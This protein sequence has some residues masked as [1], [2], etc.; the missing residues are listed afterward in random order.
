MGISDQETPLGEGSVK[1]V[2]YLKALDDIGYT[3]FLTI[4]RECG[5]DPAKDI[6]TA[7]RF[8]NNIINVN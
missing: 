6:A 5:D 8:L 3:G 1:Y 2:D 7:V 4:E